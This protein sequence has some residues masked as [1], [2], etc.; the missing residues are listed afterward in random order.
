MPQ[1]TIARSARAKVRATVRR[2]SA[3]MPQISAIASGG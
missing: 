3:G 1:N 2:V